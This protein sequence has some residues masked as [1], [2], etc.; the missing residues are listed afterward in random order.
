MER[1]TRCCVILSMAKTYLRWK[2][3]LWN[4]AGVRPH[5][6]TLGL[7]SRAHDRGSIYITSI[8]TNFR[9]L[10]LCCRITGCFLYRGAVERGLGQRNFKLPSNSGIF[11]DSTTTT[12]TFHPETM[13]FLIKPRR[14]DRVVIGTDNYAEMSGEDATNSASVELVSRRRD[15]IFQGKRGGCC[16]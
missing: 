12:F 7:T 2:G 9:T 10:R 8:W 6:Y 15:H 4:P 5:Q 3:E 13:R 14:G 11:D 16:L 1:D